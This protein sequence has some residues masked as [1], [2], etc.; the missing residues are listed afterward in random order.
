MHLI[1]NKNNN[2]MSMKPL[3]IFGLFFSLMIN[4][5]TQT[6]EYLNTIAITKLDKGDYRVIEVNLFIKK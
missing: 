5:Y 1:N 4:F 3:M 6:V 2:K